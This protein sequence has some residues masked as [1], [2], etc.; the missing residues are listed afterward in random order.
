M[1][2]FSFFK[3]PKPRKFHYQSIYRDERKEDLEKKIE[4]ARR[5]I[6][7]EE[8]PTAEEIKE[9]IAGSFIEQSQ[10]LRRRNRKGKPSSAS[11]N[12]LILFI[13]LLLLLLYWFFR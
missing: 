11:L 9:N 6:N 5:E 1:A 13:V 8:E 2:I 7:G 10:T 12:R 3:Q 4:K